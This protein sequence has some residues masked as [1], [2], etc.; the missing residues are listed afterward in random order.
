MPR[1]RGRTMRRRRSFL[2]AG[3]LERPEKKLGS[4]TVLKALGPVVYAL[5]VPD[6][7][8]KIGYSTDLPNRMR[9]F[10]RTSE[11]EILAILPGGTLAEEQ[12]IHARLRDHVAYG[13]EFY[14]PT[15][16]VVAEVNGMREQ[17]G[18]DHLTGV[19]L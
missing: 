11:A 1:V 16:E 15:P 4:I 3:N 10:V 5:R 9:R 6:G 7:A 19:S 12:A 17:I 13:R 14:H 8:I 18:L 2:H